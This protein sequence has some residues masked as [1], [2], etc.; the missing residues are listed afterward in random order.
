MSLT[1]AQERNRL[2][3]LYRA[4]TTSVRLELAQA[5]LLF[6]SNL[7]PS[8]APPPR[9]TREISALMDENSRKKRDDES[10]SGDLLKAYMKVLNEEYGSGSH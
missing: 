6:S 1:F 2:F 8:F 9:R 5:S 3:A 4:A 7:C 10:I